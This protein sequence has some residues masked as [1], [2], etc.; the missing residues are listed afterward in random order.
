MEQKFG[1]MVETMQIQ[2]DKAFQKIAELELN[3]RC[4]NTGYETQQK[5]H[6]N[7]ET[8]GNKQEFEDVLEDQYTY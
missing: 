8:L 2:M 4:S 7:Q 6:T 1:Q 5:D 3:Q